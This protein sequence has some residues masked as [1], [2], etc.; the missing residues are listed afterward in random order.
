MILA[1]VLFGGLVTEGRTTEETEA[2]DALRQQFIVKYC[3]SCHG[4]EKQEGEFSITS[5]PYELAQEGS[6]DKWEQVLEYVANSDMPPEEAKKRPAAAQRNS[7]LEILQADMAA[8]DLKAKV[9]GTPIRRLNRAEY[10][11]TLRDLLQFREIR[12]PPTFPED[13]NERHFD[14]IPAGVHLS[15]T[16]LDAY[17]EVATEMANRIVPLPDPPQ[18]QSVARFEDMGR[19]PGRAWIKGKERAYYFTGV[20]IAGWTGAYWDDTFV[21]HHCGVYRVRIRASAEADAGIDGRPLRLGFYAFNPD[22]YDLR[23]RV[24]RSLIPRVGVLDVN[25][26]EP[27]IVECNVT[28]ERGETFHVYCENR[29]KQFYP[30]QRS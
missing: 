2:R 15:P 29:L 19:D 18:V 25:N 3:S 17:M 11:N 20:N 5:L 6:R 13:V 21:A 12:L 14:T 28:L 26:R 24:N 30:D 16:H 23:K 7:F 4:D 10:L 1:V 9:G 22:D 27:G 8:A